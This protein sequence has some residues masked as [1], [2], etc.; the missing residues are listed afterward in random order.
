MH[1]VL[2]LII[3]QAHKDF[4]DDD[5]QKHQIISIPVYRLRLNA[6]KRKRCETHEE[7]Y[8]AMCCENCFELACSQCDNIGCK[9]QQGKTESL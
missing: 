8:Y 9:A 3:L 6:Y 7:E 2:M 4:F 5:K 1:F